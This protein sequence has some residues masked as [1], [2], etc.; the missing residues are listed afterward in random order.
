MDFSAVATT[1]AALLCATGFALGLERVLMAQEAA[2]IQAVNVPVVG[3]LIFLAPVMEKGTPVDG[4]VHYGYGSAAKYEMA[5]YAYNLAIGLRREGFCLEFDVEKHGRVL[6]NSLKRANKLGARFTI[7]LGE[8]ELK[9][10]EVTLKDMQGGEQ[11]R[12]KAGDVVAEV[13][14][15]L[16]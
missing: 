7:L 8:D 4:E 2:K 13:K 9:A 15:T 3:P 5:M 6:A 12:V 14:K 16:G 11:R 1:R 10:N